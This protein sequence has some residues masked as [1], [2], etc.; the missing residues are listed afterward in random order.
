MASVVL[1]Y[2]CHIFVVSLCFFRIFNIIFKGILW[3]HWR[4]P[5]NICLLWSLDSVQLCSLSRLTAPGQSW[6]RNKSSEQNLICITHETISYPKIQNIIN[7]IVLGQLSERI[8][9]II[10][11]WF[12]EF[13]SMNIW[14][15]PFFTVN[16]QWPMVQYPDVLIIYL[17]AYIVK[18]GVPLQLQI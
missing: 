18:L 7:V 3:N 1:P 13:N 2:I 9:W 8:Q 6:P 10:W 12:N 11:I 5:T 4:Q 16:S 14:I 15:Y 17:S